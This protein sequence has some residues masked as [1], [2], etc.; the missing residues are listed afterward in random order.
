MKRWLAFE[1]FVPTLR[2]EFRSGERQKP[3]V[4]DYELRNDGLPVTVMRA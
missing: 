1:C 3:Q 2:R 4:W